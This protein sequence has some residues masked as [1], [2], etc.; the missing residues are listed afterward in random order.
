[1]ELKGKGGGG[2]HVAGCVQGQS[3]A[4]WDQGV[5][6]AID[7]NLWRSIGYPKIVEAILSVPEEGRR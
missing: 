1:M 3:G 6:L 4:D 5:R 2:R 7:E